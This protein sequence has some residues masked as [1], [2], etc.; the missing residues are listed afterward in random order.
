MVGSDLGA[1][2]TM[3]IVD[4]L[5]D[6]VRRRDITS[7][8]DVFYLLEARIAEKFTYSDKQIFDEGE[9]VVLFVGINGT[10]KTTTV[11]KLAKKAVD[12][13]RKVILGSADTFRA[14]AIEQ[15]EV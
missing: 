8:Q 7:V 12:A 15:L 4:D 1:V 11:G 14:A 13:G 10:G 3:E 9:A 5:R 2:I 6:E